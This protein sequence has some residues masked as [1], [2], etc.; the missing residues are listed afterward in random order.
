MTRFPGCRLRISYIRRVKNFL[1]A[2]VIIVICRLLAAYTFGTFDDAFITYRYAQNLAAGHGLVYNLQERVLGTTAPLFAIIGTIPVF[3]SVSVPKFFV[4]FNILC[5]LGTGYLIYRHVFKRNPVLLTLFT[6]LFSLDPAA[7]RIAVGGME[8][9][10]FLFCSLLG[11]VLYFHHKKFLAFIILA[12]IYFLRPEAL[13]LFVVL[14]GYEWYSTKKMPW[15]YAVACLLVMALPLY[16]MLHY[17]GNIIPQSVL[18]KNQGPQGSF[19]A[20]VRDIFFPRPFNYFLFP[21]AVYGAVKMAGKSR[22][23]TVIACWT[24]CYAA[25]YCIQGPWILNWYIYSIE[26]SQIIFAA[27]AIR[28]ICLILRISLSGQKIFLLSPVLAVPVWI[29]VC[30]LQGRSAV[31][32]NIYDRLKT[33]FSRGRYMEKKVFFADDIGALGFYSGGYIYDDLMLVTPQAIQYANARERI[34]Q[35]SPDYLFLYTD[36]S[37]LRLVLEDSAISGKYRFVA[38]YARNGKT[39]LPDKAEEGN[40]GYVQDYMLW[41]RKE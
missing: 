16:G 40:V 23:L 33:D 22:Y 12:V 32:T 28:K 25:A 24:V 20:L 13:I 14:M 35:L 41:K 37:Y 5:D 19:S 29:F 1:S 36:K 39:I 38:R 7:N 2:C 18:A 27:L 15:K 8:A 6:I 17:Y 3:L 10:L 26:V 21:M 11:L 34:L 4:V 31:A 9:N 30:H